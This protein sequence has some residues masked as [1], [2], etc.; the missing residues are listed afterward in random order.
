[1]AQT[2]RRR[3]RS[4]A[5]AGRQRP[6][7]SQRPT[8]PPAAPPA[9]GEAAI[10]ESMDGGAY[11][12]QQIGAAMIMV[13][14]PRDEQVIANGIATV[15]AESGFRRVDNHIC[16]W[17]PWQ[18]NRADGGCS[19]EEA[20]SANL[21]SSTKAALEKWHRGNCFACLS[22]PN[23]WQAGTDSA[24]GGDKTLARKLLA[25]SE[26]EL[27]GIAL[28]NVSGNIQT[29]GDIA[30][31]IISA[32]VDALKAIIA[33]IA[34][35]FQPSLWLRIGKVVLGAV[36]LIIGVGIL[37]RAMLGVDLGIGERTARGVRYARAA[38]DPGAGPTPAERR[39]GRREIN[40]VLEDNPDVRQSQRP[41]DDP[42]F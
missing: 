15:R 28:A 19:A 33:F 17:G 21:I 25:M 39:S 14:F 6:S 27:S 41:L 10:S 38:P 18:L 29:G 23:P 11:S 22:G 20:C 2:T 8:T 9:T 12:A 31:D 1:M 42:P 13:G 26:I 4:R 5:K 16:C 3:T 36:A 32:P 24:G 35:L 40:Q 7:G 30:K 37:A 34:R